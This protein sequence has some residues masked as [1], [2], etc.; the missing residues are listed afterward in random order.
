MAQMHKHTDDMHGSRLVRT[1][2]VTFCCSSIRQLQQSKMMPGCWRQ[3]HCASNWLNAQHQPAQAYSLLA[4][5]RGWHHL[6][7][8]SCPCCLASCP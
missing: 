2:Q 7:S 3:A 6:P 1:A 8:H 4:P 5:R